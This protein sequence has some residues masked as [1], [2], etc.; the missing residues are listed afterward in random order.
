VYL[1]ARGSASGTDVA[2]GLGISQPAFSRLA[3]ELAGDLFVTGR[4]RSVRYAAYR[5]IPDVGRRVPIYEIDELGSARHVAILH[6]TRPNGFFVE[7]LVDDVHSALFGD[8][9]Y[10]LHDLRPSGFM[11]RLVPR[12]HP[13]LGAPNDIQLWTANHC[14]H[15]LTKYGWNLPGSFIVGDDAFRLYLAN[16]TGPTDAVPEK[17]RS[18]KYAE[19][20][21]DVLGAGPAG[22]SVAGEQPK[23]VASKSP[24]PVDVLVKFSPPLTN[25]LSQRIA[26]LLVAE[27]ISHDVL[28]SCGHETPR[29]EL[30]ESGNRLFLEVERFDRTAV[31]G[32]RGLLSLFAL[33]AEF[34]GRL[35]SWTDSADHLA[36][37]NRIA[38]VLR[39]EIAWRELYGRLIGN[40]DMHAGNLSFV[41]HGTRVVGLAPIYDMVPM[42]YAPQQTQLPQVKF[43]APIPDPTQ[44][45]IWEAARVAAREF[46]ATAR[47]HALVSAD[48]RRI[49]AGNMAVLDEVKGL[50]DLLPVATRRAH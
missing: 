28:R 23:F 19:F 10:F 6:A 33:D 16:R 43:V 11:G 50:G 30:I 9:P 26:D 25:P 42:M 3:R 46:W 49:A 17:R 12:R 20:A 41:T 39:E 15:Y 14:L 1:S 24:G 7:A 37:Q 32:R 31:G 2:R 48:F 36:A 38:P 22:S 21:N 45:P 44:A 13:D 8:L 5:E 29:S 35:N 18:V 34:V 27:H 40:T 4:A 47:T